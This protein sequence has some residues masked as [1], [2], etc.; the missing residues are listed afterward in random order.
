MNKKEEFDRLR[1][2]KSESLR[3]SKLD[4]SLSAKKAEAEYQNYLKLLFK[5]YNIKEG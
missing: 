5:K 3:I 4:N 2:L 1:F